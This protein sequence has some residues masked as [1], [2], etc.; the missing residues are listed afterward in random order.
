MGMIWRTTSPSIT[1]ANNHTTPFQY[2]T[3][4]HLTKTIFPSTKFESYTYENIGKLM[5]RIDRKNQTISYA[6]TP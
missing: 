1:G 2:D 5:T 4:Q 3:Q 6:M